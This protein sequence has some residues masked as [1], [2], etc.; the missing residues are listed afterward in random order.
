ML[1][2]Y[3]CHSHEQVETSD[4]RLSGPFPDKAAALAASNLPAHV[5]LTP[6]ELTVLEWLVWCGGATEN[7]GG[8]LLTRIAAEAGLNE[9]AVGNTLRS[10]AQKQVIGYRAVPGLG[11]T[12]VSLVW[13]AE[14]VSQRLGGPVAPDRF[15]A[16]PE[17]ALRL[18]QSEAAVVRWLVEHFGAVSDPAGQIVPALAQTLSLSPASVRK[19]LDRLSEKGVTTHNRQKGRGTTL[20]RL[21][22]PFD[23]ARQ[24]ARG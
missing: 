15:Q 24:L 19:A 7:P 9:V 14:V 4:C 22:L 3:W 16:R 8:G 20:L 13:D 23:Q 17:L 2:Y 12:H 21:L 6:T 18:N 5:K 1:H 10:L 11:T